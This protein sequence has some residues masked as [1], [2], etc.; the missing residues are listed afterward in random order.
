MVKTQCLI[1]IVLLNYTKVLPLVSGQQHPY[2]RQHFQHP[3]G[4]YLEVILVVN[5]RRCQSKDNN[6]SE[7]SVLDHYN[8]WIFTYYYTAANPAFTSCASYFHNTTETT[9]VNV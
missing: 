3:N 6:L 9:T 2:H 7:F 4:P 8:I 5:L 1:G